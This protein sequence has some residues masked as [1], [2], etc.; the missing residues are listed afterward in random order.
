[1]PLTKSATA[2]PVQASATNSIGGTTTTNP[3]L[4]INY[5]VSGVAV[6]TNGGTGPS[7]ECQVRVD[8]SAD[9]STWVIGYVI[10]G[11]GTTANAVTRI[12]YTFAPM[13]AGGD[14]AYYRLVFT[15][16]TGQAVT[17]QADDSTT[18]SPV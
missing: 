11:G 17:V 1:M 2:R 6:I 10:G 4:A 16:N 5:G 15:G 3:G 9:N 8:F 7:T 14:W 12:P 18:T 13:G